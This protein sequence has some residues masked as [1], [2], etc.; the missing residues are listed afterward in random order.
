VT[1]ERDPVDEGAIPRLLETVFATY[2][3]D[4]RA[5]APASIRRRILA[6]L[7]KTGLRSIED[8]ERKIVSDR[9]FA[10]VVIEDLTVN[11][12]E[13]FR[14]PAFFRAVRERLVPLLRTYPRLNIWS[15]GCATGEEAYSMAI[16]LAEE[17]LYE[18]C[19]I[20]ATD[21][22]ARVIQHAKEGIYPASAI[23]RFAA[24]YQLAGGSSLLSSYFTEAYDRVAMRD[25][26]RRNIVFFQHDLVGDQ[27]F[28]EMQVVLCRHVFIY[29]NR[30][31]QG[32]IASKLA[33][34]LRSGG[35]LG[36]GP[37]DWLPAG[38][39]DQFSA[40]APHERIYQFQP[41]SAPGRAWTED[42]HER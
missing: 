17:G 42:R 12:S 35:F 4:L 30:E 37:H 11:V 25:S 5:Y 40:V 21:L 23:P 29:F 22:S 8:L 6:A 39:C 33:Q 18:R 34:S 13:M 26:L 28:G 7:A 19:Q 9:S 32:R 2:G 15:S 41:A 16:L 38:V 31:L 24:N 20:Y 14:D 3:Y 27:V 1:I 10:A 36:L